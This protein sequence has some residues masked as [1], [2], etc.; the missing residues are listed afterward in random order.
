MSRIAFLAAAFCIVSITAS[1]QQTTSNTTSGPQTTQA[2]SIIQQSIATMTGGA[3]VTDVTMTGTTTITKSGILAAVEAASQ[4]TSESGPITLV[5]TASGKG[6]NTTTTG[7]GTSV[8]V[9]DISQLSPVLGV[10]GKDG[11]PHTLQTVSALTPHPGWFYPALLLASGQS[12]AYAASYVGHEVWNGEAVEH[13]AIW[14]ISGSTSDTTALQRA[15]QH[16]IYLDSTTLLPVGI[17]Y[18][19]HPYDSRNPGASFDYQRNLPD[20]V[21]EVQFS[22]YRQVQ[23]REVPLHI[24]WTMTV[25]PFDT[26]SDLVGDIQISSATFNTGVIVSV[27]SS[28]EN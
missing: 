11:V 17:T 25:M 4:P 6:Q 19:A 28:T 7:S 26:A 3:P 14:R 27:P 8:T 21:T 9:Q 16:E 1:A 18:I 24:R 15:S 12:S 20:P 10:T 2:A 23:G 13:I 5:A 22:D